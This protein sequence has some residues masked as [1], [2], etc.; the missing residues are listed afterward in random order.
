ML[1]HLA[2]AGSQGREKPNEGVRGCSPSSPAES[3]SLQRP[4]RHHCLALPWRGKSKRVKGQRKGSSS[5]STCTAPCRGWKRRG[6]HGWGHEKS[7]HRY[8]QRGWDRGVKSRLT[9]DGGGLVRVVATDGITEMMG[10]SHAEVPSAQIIQCLSSI[11]QCTN[12]NK[13]PAG[14]FAVPGDIGETPGTPCS[15][16]R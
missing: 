15:H 7:F 16:G 5:V 13:S 14:N 2:P 1:A 6:G 4:L 3:F 8:W 12:T 10:A 9:Q 11:H